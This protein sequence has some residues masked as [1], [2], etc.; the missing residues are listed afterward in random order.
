MWSLWPV[1]SWFVFLVNA[2]K[3]TVVAL[4]FLFHKALILYWFGTERIPIANQEQQIDPIDQG[5]FQFI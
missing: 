3:S 4:V 2:W 5:L 1:I